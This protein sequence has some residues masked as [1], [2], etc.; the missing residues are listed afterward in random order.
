MN[1]PVRSFVGISGQNLLW[2][3]TSCF[4]TS[5]PALGQRFL[6]CDILPALQQAAQM[7]FGPLQMKWGFD[8]HSLAVSV[9]E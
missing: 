6:L 3:I 2:D 1:F 5:L 7:L 8:T 4:V 9:L